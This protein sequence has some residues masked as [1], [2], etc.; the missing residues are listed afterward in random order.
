ARGREVRQGG[1]DARFAVMAGPP[2]LHARLNLFRAHAD[3][4]CD[5]P[6]LVRREL[7]LQLRPD[8]VLLLAE[9]AAVELPADDNDVNVAGRAVG[10][11]HKV[12]GILEVSLL[13]HVVYSLL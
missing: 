11:V 10:D 1:V 7:A 9:P 5:M 6:P 3:G 13:Q 8:Y 12:R 4:Q 2:D